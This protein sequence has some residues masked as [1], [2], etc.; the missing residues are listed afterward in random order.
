M[1]ALADY[2]MAM[3]INPGNALAMSKRIEMY[4]VIGDTRK[5]YGTYM[6]TFG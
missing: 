4:E 5:A 2:S 1:E 6:P 3:M